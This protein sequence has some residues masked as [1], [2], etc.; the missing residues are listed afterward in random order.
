MIFSKK[1][2]YLENDTKNVLKSMK[3]VHFDVEEAQEKI[4]Q[5]SNKRSAGNVAP[6][7]GTQ[8]KH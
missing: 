6:A 7:R 5:K 8:V 2:V 4:A 1:V 3:Q